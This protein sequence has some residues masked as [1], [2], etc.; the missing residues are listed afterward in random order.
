LVSNVVIA[1]SDELP[2]RSKLVQA[3]AE[4]KLRCVADRFTLNDAAVG[5]E[6]GKKGV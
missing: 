2:S 1:A 6:E 4:A 3:T 5:K